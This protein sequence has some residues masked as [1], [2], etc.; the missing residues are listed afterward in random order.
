[1]R[2]KWLIAIVAVVITVAVL[3]ATLRMYNPNPFSEGTGIIA[4]EWEFA[5]YLGGTYYNE[6]A[7]GHSSLAFNVSSTAGSQVYILSQRGK[8]LPLTSSTLI[9]SSTADCKIDWGWLGTG[10]NYAFLT[11]NGTRWIADTNNG[12]NTPE[13]TTINGYDPST[14]WRKLRI[15]ATSIQTKYYIDDQL[16]ATHTSR[17]P[18][19]EFQ[20]YGEL[21]S[22]GS[23]SKLYI[24]SHAY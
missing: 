16:V 14:S 3:L 2:K 7:Y 24:T 20:F 10:N 22:T 6:T 11:W 4:G 8:E 23:A 12:S 19:G 17:I 21:T 18:S 15:E 13:T 5:T 9:R 1:M